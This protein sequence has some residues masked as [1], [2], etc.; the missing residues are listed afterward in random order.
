[1]NRLAR[2]CCWLLV[3]EMSAVAIAALAVRW[4]D[5]IHHSAAISLFGWRVAFCVGFF[6]A[7]MAL[8]IWMTER[9]LRP[10]GMAFS[11]SHHRVKETAAVATGLLMAGMQGWFAAY[12]AF[13]GAPM[14]Q[15]SMQQAACFFGGLFF[16]LY[17]NA[18]AKIAPPTGPAAP[19]PGS[20]I[21][22]SLRNGWA[23]VLAGIALM[24]IAFAPAVVRSPA[25]LAL[26]PLFAAIT[27][28]RRRQ[29]RP[30]RRPEAP[31]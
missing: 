21:R 16:V 2:L 24:A 22:K 6:P 30:V 28:S 26:L 19:D 17:G 31:A 13:H 12:F 10:R 3:V 4:R 7:W 5:I 14:Q 29:Q 15:V 1:M 9:S 27:I 18:S 23:T 20:W 11:A 8:G 25:T